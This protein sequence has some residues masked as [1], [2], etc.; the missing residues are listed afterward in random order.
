MW[1]H[2]NQE[3]DIFLLANGITVYLPT[4][5]THFSEW[6][7][8]PFLACN[9]GGTSKT[10]QRRLLSRKTN[11]TLEELEWAAAMKVCQKSL[12]PERSHM[13][14]WGLLTVGWHW[15]TLW[16]AHCHYLSLLQ[17]VTKLGTQHQHIPEDDKHT[18][19]QIW[20]KAQEHFNDQDCSAMPVGP[21]GQLMESEAANL[22]VSSVPR[23]LITITCCPEWRKAW[24]TL[25]AL[26]LV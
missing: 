22:I 13:R 23:S 8:F 4:L 20:G 25:I 6:Q 2:T 1:Q 16:P 24:G 17:P 19:C 15:Q 10:Y 11:M 3:S 21:L 7:V 26:V 18:H 14:A 12:P 9:V 5:K